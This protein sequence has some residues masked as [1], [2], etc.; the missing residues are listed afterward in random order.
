MKV[1]DPVLINVRAN[2]IALENA[3]IGLTAVVAAIHIF[4]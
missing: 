3:K 4:W 1:M 2:E